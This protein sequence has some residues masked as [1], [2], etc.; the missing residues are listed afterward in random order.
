MGK[1]DV[2]RQAAIEAVTLSFCYLTE[3]TIVLICK[4]GVSS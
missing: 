4:F 2:L 3:P 1:I